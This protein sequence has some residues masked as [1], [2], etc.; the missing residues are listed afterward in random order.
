MLARDSNFKRKNTS[1]MNN[2]NNQSDEHWKVL[3]LL[4]KEVAEEK[5]IAQQQIAER[6]GL[7]QSNVSRTFALRFKP[8][9]DN[10]LRIANAVG[11]N[12]FFEDKDATTDLAK[13]FNQAMDVLHRR[14][15][16]GISQN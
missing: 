5:G 8:T 4:L 7:L 12:F 2:N 6:T 9:L 11:V 1:R 3:V 15:I 16:D 13:C 14:N 10:F